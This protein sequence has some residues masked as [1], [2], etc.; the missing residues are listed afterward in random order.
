MKDTQVQTEYVYV[1]VRGDLTPPQKCV[2]SCHAAMEAAKHFL[3]D[4]NKEHPHLVV[5]T[6]KTEDHLKKAI[7]NLKNTDIKFKVFIE[8]DI[9]DELTAIATEPLFGN[10]RKFFKKYQLLK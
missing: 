2:Q 3:P 1:L 6:V 4:Y 5:C 9:G 7:E 8:P 10:K